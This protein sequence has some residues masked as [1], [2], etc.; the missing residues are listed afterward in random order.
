MFW[1]K[2]SPVSV[3]STDLGEIGTADHLEQPQRALTPA[4]ARAPSSWRRRG[5]AQR[6]RARSAAAT[7]RAR[8]RR[9]GPR[10]PTPR[11]RRDART[12]STTSAPRPTWLGRAREC[13]PRAMGETLPS[14][15]RPSCLD[16]RTV[17]ARRPLGARASSHAR[18]WTRSGSRW[19]PSAH[20]FQDFTKTSRWP[21]GL[22]SAR[23]TA[24]RTWRAKRSGRRV[25]DDRATAL[26]PR[27]VVPVRVDA[28]VHDAAERR[29]GTR[30]GPR[31]SGTAPDRSARA[32]C[33]AGRAPRVAVRARERELDVHRGV[34]AVV[35][36]RRVLRAPGAQTRR[37][38]R[39]TARRGRPPSRGA[40][41][42]RRTAAGRGALGD[43][44]RRTAAAR[45]RGGTA[46]RGTPARSASKWA[47]SSPLRVGLL[48]EHAVRCAVPD[49]GPALVRP[50]QAEREGGEP[51]ASTSSK[52]RSSRRRPANQ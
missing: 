2:T 14:R 48:D 40:A 43:G 17:R 34:E 50:A 1:A 46:G 47:S 35:D 18:P 6:A 38:R 7:A 39:G 52:G 21:C 33:A 36:V 32:A 24:W 22:S 49:A 23:A 9:D 31:R 4:V 16:G 45:R 20:S 11:R 8:R 19:L 41:T 12:A 44:R 25:D 30:G 26:G 3:A 5:A 37:T 13:A 15:E 29:A 28:R 10:R 42:C 51:E 27:R